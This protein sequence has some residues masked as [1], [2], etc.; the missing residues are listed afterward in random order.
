MTQKLVTTGAGAEIP[1]A[2]QLAEAKVPYDETPSTS[3]VFNHLRGETQHGPPEVLRDGATVQASAPTAQA[4][5]FDIGLELCTEAELIKLREMQAWM[6][7][8]FKSSEPYAL[9][10]VSAKQIQQRDAISS[11]LNSGE[12]TEGM[13]MD[14]RETIT[15]TFLAHLAAGNSARVRKTA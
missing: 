5:L 13:P 6:A 1:T 15:R 14:S 7:A 4:I 9:G 12:S 3:A 11:K 2:L 8:S 10:N